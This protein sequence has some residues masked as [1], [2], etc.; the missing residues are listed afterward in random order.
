M[1]P[2]IR[3][4]RATVIATTAAAIAVVASGAAVAAVLVPRT[5]ASPGS[6]R[7]DYRYAVAATSA[8]A[9]GYHRASAPAPLSIRTHRYAH[10][11]DS[12]VVTRLSCSPKVAGGG[13][14]SCTLTLLSGGRA[15]APD[16]NAVIAL[17][18]EFSA[19]F[20]QAGHGGHSG[21]TRCTMRNNAASWPVGTL[22][23][24]QSTSVSVSFR[25]GA[26]RHH[27][28]VIVEGIGL[29]G[30]EHRS[31]PQQSSTAYVPVLV[32]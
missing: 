23:P 29:W 11:L 21:R 2:G 12:K 10:R 18:P 7:S 20:C 16:T 19:R 28:K 31:Q 22:R 9:P 26:A 27:L 14:G 17:P 25:A 13:A 6:A 3:G 15:G 32:R 8:P 5:L 1:G 4:R 24:G 30:V